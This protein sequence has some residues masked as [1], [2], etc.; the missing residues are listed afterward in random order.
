MAL[1][2]A[3]TSSREA[4]GELFWDDGESLGVLEREAYTHIIFLARNVSPGT[5]PGWWEA[6]GTILGVTAL[7]W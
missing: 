7:I 4:Q 2:V 6:M 3:L 1:V 5:F